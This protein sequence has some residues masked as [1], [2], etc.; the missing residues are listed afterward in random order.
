MIK[1]SIIIG[2]LNHCEDFLKPC[3]ESIKKY[4]DLS[5]VEV[6][7][8]SNGS[9][10]N[11]REYVESLG[12][13]FKLL[14][15]DA[16]LGYARAN[17][18][19]AAAAK[20]KYLIL[21][22]NDT[23]LLDQ[24]V[25]RWINQ[26]EVPF[27]DNPKVGLSGPLLGHS[28]PGGKD[29]L[30]F[31]CVMILKE[32][33]DKLK[34]NED[35]GVGAGE[36]T[37]FCYEARKLGYIVAHCAPISGHDDVNKTVIGDF[38]IYHKGEGTMHDNP[39]W[40]SI[41]DQNSL[42]LAK[43]YNPEWYKWKISNNCE[44][45]VIDSSEDMSRFPRETAR[46]QWAAK[47]LVGKK[48]LEI[49][50]S[51]GY[52]L[53]FLPPDID[54]TGVDY[55]Q[56]IVD[57]ATKNFG[58]DKRKFIQSDINK[59][60]FKEHYD[61]IIAFEFIEHIDNGRELAQSL[62]QHCDNL[63][64]TT[65][66]S[67]IRGLWGP[68]HKLHQLQEKDF[69]NFDYYYLSEDGRFIDKPERFDGM[70]L[71]IMRWE[72]GKTYAPPPESLKY[73]GPPRVLCSIATKDRYDILASCL[74]SVA[75]QTRVPD[76][77]M[78]FEDG[79]KLDLRED[80]IYKHILRLFDI[81]NI[82][83]EVM[84]TPGRGQQVGHDIA[85]KSDFEYVW[86]LDDDEIA[87]PDVLERLLSHMKEG[88]GAVAGAVFE[89]GTTQYGGTNKLKDVLYS[90]N[91]QWGPDQG[92]HEVE[93]LYSSFL[94]RPRI[95]SYELNLSPVGHREETIFSNRLFQA[96]YKLIVD[97]SIKTYHFRQ[98]KGGIRSHTDQTMYDYDET[99]FSKYMESLGYKIIS[100]DTGL[101]DH[102]VFL[103]IVPELMKKYKHLIIGVCYPLVFK[104][105]DVTLVP[106]GATNKIRKDYQDN[107]YAFMTLNNWKGSLL[108]AYKK[109]FGV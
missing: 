4:T 91:L 21:L 50:C 28:E 10:D 53:R 20:G 29:F 108:D 79:E 14:W 25:N 71:M 94:Y 57:F 102:F 47:N 70:N 42:K 40:Q 90:P 78:I 67:E 87:E 104:D 69:P 101:G 1:Y 43:K 7:V 92:V 83:W 12:E 93:H 84:F 61:T 106:V 5:N 18:E 73:S 86:R 65:P 45:A 74:L 32:L 54:Y 96:G 44:R 6:I 16:P 41:F 19:G 35:Y 88:V 2:T 81:K 49:G 13:P 82:K 68:H 22:N 99:I 11:T 55:D 46:Y 105:L 36:D 60:D 56:T 76:K 27:L 62:K 37:E 9:T 30:V 17:N 34:L 63:L 100:L 107:V 24:P 97:T 52:G 15:F 103:Q 48:V 8:V 85:N 31:F 23:V 51:S 89:P 3:L 64:I 95:A 72:K 75:T 98:E 38:P 39:N 33:F 80:P 58:N 26:L 109:M 66:Y 77:I 59:F